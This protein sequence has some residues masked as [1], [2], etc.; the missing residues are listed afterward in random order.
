MPIYGPV[1]EAHDFSTDRNKAQRNRG[2]CFFWLWL[3]PPIFRALI[4]FKRA[5]RRVGD[6]PGAISEWVRHL[7]HDGTDARHGA[8]LRV[9]RHHRNETVVLMMTRCVRG[10][11]MSA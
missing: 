8:S 10:L 4:P 2:L 6:S 11:A 1:Y 7:M 3:Q 9:S 5:L